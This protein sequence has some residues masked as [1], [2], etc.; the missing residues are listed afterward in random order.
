MPDRTPPTAFPPADGRADPRCAA[1]RGLTMV[2]L[3][4][5]TAILAVL[6]MGLASSYLTAA[7]LNSLTEEEA[8][9]LKAI[10]SQ[11]EQ[12]LATSRRTS[13]NPVT[14][15][16]Q[17]YTGVD[18]VIAWYGQTA[19]Q[20]FTVPEMSTTGLTTAITLRLDE[21]YVPV[22]LGAGGTTVNADGEQFGT[23]ELDG[24]LSGDSGF[25]SEDLSGGFDAEIVPVEIRV[26]W[27]TPF[28]TVTRRRFIMLAR[29][30][31]N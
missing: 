23:L 28:G 15:G 3:I 22:E 13:G 10:E 19:N 9:V 30:E 31:E 24:D 8:R 7:R 6:I 2:E 26:R 5:A 21:T 20:T 11:R 17:N 25:R 1:E 12:V 4:I 29:L 14:V 27:T 16:G 18:A